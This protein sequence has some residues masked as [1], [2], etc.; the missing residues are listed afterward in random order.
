MGSPKVER[1]AWLRGAQ[2][3]SKIT[4]KYFSNILY[5]YGIGLYGKILIYPAFLSTTRF[6]LTHCSLIGTKK[7]CG[8]K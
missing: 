4:A 3:V 6:F 5:Q 1:L 2:Q 8:G 7:K